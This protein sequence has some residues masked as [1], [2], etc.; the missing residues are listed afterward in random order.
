MGIWYEMDIEN[1]RFFC[2]QVYKREKKIE[3]NIAVWTYMYIL[4]A[5]ILSPNIFGKVQ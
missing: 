2:C 5:A 1:M 3:E 4:A